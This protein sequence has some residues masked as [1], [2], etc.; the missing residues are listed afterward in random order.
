MQT[1]VVE[2]GDEAGQETQGLWC[3]HCCSSQS[4]QDGHRCWSVSWLEEQGFDT[5]PCTVLWRWGYSSHRPGVQRYPEIPYSFKTLNWSGQNHC[6]EGL[7]SSWCQVL[8]WSSA[9]SGA[10]HQAVRWRP[11]LPSFMMLQASANYLWLPVIVFFSA[12][13]LAWYQAFQFVSVLMT[14]N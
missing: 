3:T 12:H 2:N 1:S 9:R 6:I 10:P 11:I 13:L 7:W 14:S 5:A 8:P 4:F